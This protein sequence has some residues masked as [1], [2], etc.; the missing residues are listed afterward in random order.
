[1]RCPWTRLREYP[2]P[3]P[4]GHTHGG[5]ARRALHACVC[6]KLENMCM[7]ACMHAHVEGYEGIIGGARGRLSEGMRVS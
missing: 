5:S 2:R 7:H 4:A 1:M 6:R 3:G